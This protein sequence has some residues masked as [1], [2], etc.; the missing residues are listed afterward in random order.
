[1]ILGR[2]ERPEDLMAQADEALYRAKIRGRN[3]VEIHGM[4]DKIRFVK[5]GKSV[6]IKE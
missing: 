3:R 1:M 5:M 4:E 6:K 2:A